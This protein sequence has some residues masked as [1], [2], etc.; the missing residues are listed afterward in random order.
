[1]VNT[2]ITGISNLNKTVIQTRIEKVIKKINSVLFAPLTVPFKNKIVGSRKRKTE[3]NAGIKTAA[4]TNKKITGNSL[5]KGLS[6]E[7]NLNFLTEDELSTI[8]SLK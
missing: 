4:K 5:E 6:F 2:A 8:Q 3:P 1:M 7:D